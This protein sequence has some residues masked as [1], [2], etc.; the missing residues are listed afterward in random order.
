MCADW[1]QVGKPWVVGSVADLGRWD[2]RRSKIV[3]GEKRKIVAL[4]ADKD[5]DI[6]VLVGGQEVY[7]HHVWHDGDLEGV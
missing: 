1:V 5:Y 2:S 4:S 3:S 7:S 6:L